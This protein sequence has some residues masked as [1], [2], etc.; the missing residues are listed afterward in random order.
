[1]NPKTADNLNHLPRTILMYLVISTLTKV[2][3]SLN[4]RI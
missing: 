4:Y 3:L 1:M 2:V